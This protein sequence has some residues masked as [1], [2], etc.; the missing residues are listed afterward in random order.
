MTTSKTIKSQIAS[1][2][3]FLVSK[4][5]E[6]KAVDFIYFHFISLFYFIFY[7]LDIGLGVSMI[8]HV[9]ITNCY[10]I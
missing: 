2:P 5:L 4:L 1:P 10:T 8:S 6:L 3:T 9:T 7:F